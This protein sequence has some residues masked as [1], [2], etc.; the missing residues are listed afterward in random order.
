MHEWNKESHLTRNCFVF[1]LDI[2]KNS[3]QIYIN[4]TSQEQIS[5][6]LFCTVKIMLT[7]ELH[8]AEFFL[9]S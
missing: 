6:I 8:E 3:D 9:T 2:Q 1:Q 4:H 7:N 5:K